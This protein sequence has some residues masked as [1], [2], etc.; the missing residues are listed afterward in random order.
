MSGGESVR[1]GG[2]ICGVAYAAVLL[3]LAWARTLEAAFLAAGAAALALAVALAWRRGRSVGVARWSSQPGAT[4]LLLA[5]ACAALAVA[6]AAGLVAERRL[7]RLDRDWERLAA[8]REARLAREL[9]RGMERLIERCRLAAL[10]AAERAARPDRGDM[11][12]VL[13]SL[14]AQAGVAALALFD[15]AGELIAWAGEHRGALP[16]E[17]KV[18][19][20]PVLYAER[21]LF[22]YLYVSQPVEGRGERVVAAALLQ[23]GFVLEQQGAAG[24]A[25]RFAAAMG[26]RPY[27]APGPGPEG[28]WS[29]IAGADT[30]LH[31][32]FEPTARAEWRMGIAQTARRTVVPLALVALALLSAAWLRWFGGRGRRRGIVASAPLLGAT[33]ALIIAPLG[34]MAGADSLFSPALY[35]LPTLGEPTLGRLLAVLLPLAALIAVARPVNLGARANGLALAVGAAAVAIGFAGGLRLIVAGAA[36]SL[37]E[38]GWAYWGAVQGAAV[39]TLTMVAALALPQGRP[40]RVRVGALAGGAALCAA[41]AGLVLLRWRLMQRIDAWMPMLW[42]APFALLAAGIAPYAGRASRIARWLIAGWLAASAVL[43][44]LWVTEVQAK[45]NAAE[46]E[47]A[48][49][50]SRPD[51]FLDYL[52][53]RFA[54]EALRRDARGEDGVEMLYRAWVGSGLAREAYPARIRLWRP[55]GPRLELAVGDA[56]SV[57][58]APGVPDRRLREAIDRARASGLPSLEPTFGTGGG[59]QILAVPLGGAGAVT[60]VVP[61]RRSLSRATVLAPILGGEPIADTRLTLVPVARVGGH[62]TQQ[63][64]WV[65]T[66]TGWRSEKRLRYPDGEYHAHLELRLAGIGVLAARGALLLAMDLAVLTLLWAI[67]RTARGEP[68]SPPGGWTA[69][70]GSF[71][72]RV[73]LALFAFFLLPTIVFGAAAYRALAGEAARA[74]RVVAERAAAQAVE[75]FAELPGNWRAIS[76][77]IGEEVLYYHRGELAQGSSPEVV[78]LGLF[79][80]WMPPSV[81]AVLQTGEEMGVVEMRTLGRRPYIVAYRRLP[82]GTVAVPVSMTAGEAS[83][84]QAELAHLIL[85]AA[86]LGGLLSLGLSLLVGRALARP[87]GQLRRAAAAV[88]AGRL[89]VRLPESGAG[90]FGQLFA[91]F[92]RMARR[93]RDARAKELHTARV[94]A[95]GEMSRQVAHEIKNPLTPI[96]LAVQHLRRA[97]KDGRPEFG[98]I[99]ETNVE[100]ILTEIDR[101][102]EIARAF[103]RYGAPPEAAGPVEDVDVAA[104]IHE[105]LTLYRSDT[106]VRFRVEVEEGLPRVR[107]RAGELKEVLLNLLENAYTALEGR[108]TIT[109]S[110]KRDR[111]RVELTVRDDGPGIPPELVP[112]IFEPHFSTRSAGT[113]LGLAIVRRLVE[114][115]GGALSAESELG[116]GTAIRIRLPVSRVSIAASGS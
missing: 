37:L 32:Q 13:G 44:H 7:A 22:G 33:L 5:V 72:A 57:R 67:G 6:C 19:S 1:A 40:G 23:T 50:G 59:G 108:G 41:L 26:A 94:L 58:R 115:W 107:A 34:A 51:P 102:T 35:L 66:E 101:L 9:D 27:F 81:Y 55:G 89:M 48:T 76:E 60:V 111:E 86:L 46:R 105:A 82:A 47:L 3:V 21:P 93:L 113:G 64:Q 99:L 31:A 84:R 97:Y 42:A 56:E 112:R 18:G 88:G 90:E 80:A 70:T 78:E 39:L 54:D 110:A 100:Q 85:F 63:A 17:A 30:V 8:E 87:I 74:A 28:A 15:E 98:G 95:W 20:R 71:R 109:V 43:P 104:A 16:P 116:Q 52:L 69:W 77:R 4:A 92:N 10:R 12:A 83:V 96:K 79:G 25:D 38:G 53:H 2:T 114:G 11:F 91:S 14:R 103:S 73:T 75:A 45:L 61:P 24:F 106:A 36:P 29:L 49:L 68:P 62:A 65:P